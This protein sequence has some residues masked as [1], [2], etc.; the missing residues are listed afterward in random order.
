M[1][2][3]CMKHGAGGKWYLNA[4]HYSNQIVE[5]YNLRD[6]LMEQYKNFEQI[7]VR[8]VHGFNAVGMG[9]KLRIP[10]IGRIVKHTAEKLLHST[11]PPTNP[12]KPEGH[13]G[14]VIPLEDAI[15]IL[16]TCAVEPIIEKNCMCR[17]MNRGVKEA[18]CINFGVM[19]EIID[20]LPRFI[21]EKDKYFLT[22]KQAVERFREHNRKGYIGTIWFGPYPYINNLCSCANPECAGLRPRVDYGLKSIYKAE[23]IVHHHEADCTGCGACVKFCQFGAIEHDPLRKKITIN[24]DKCF[25]CGL[26]RHACKQNAIHLHPRDETPGFEKDY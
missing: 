2:D 16:E 25:G 22:R 5:K 17:Y 1:C 24:M 21:P 26:C 8:K 6:F 4:E 9:Y 10:I 19:S 20:K 11:N 13:I 18:C 3:L 14:Q 12:F 7:S 23:Y 15:A